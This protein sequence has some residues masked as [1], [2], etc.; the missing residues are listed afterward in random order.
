MSVT[1]K[2]MGQALM[3]ALNKEIDWA[4]DEIKVAL[5]TSAHAPDQD[6]DVYYDGSN[7][8]TEVTQAGGYTTGG[9]IAATPTIGYTAGTNV[10]KLDANDVTWADSTITA[11]YAVIYDNTPASNKP[12]LGYVDFGADF[13]SSSGN[14]T[15]TWSSDG[16]FTCTAS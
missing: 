5:L 3:M 9:A 4:S 15:I 14:F 6:T 16:I 12:I 13:S 11:R 8:W 7:G 2:M 10:I 1:A